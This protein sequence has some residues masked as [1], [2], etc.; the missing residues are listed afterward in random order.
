MNEMNTY[1]ILK[2][3]C[4]ACYSEKFI[5]PKSESRTEINLKKFDLK[6]AAKETFNAVIIGKRNT[7]KSVLISEILYY[8]TKSKIPR[9][10]V[11]S[12]TEESN[13]FFCKYI[14]DTY[15]FNAL[16]VESRLEMIVQNQKDLIMKKKLGH[17]PI[18]TDLKVVVVLDDI[19]YKKGALR[20]EI[21][22]EIFCNGRHYDI[23]VILAAQHVM[24]LDPAVRSNCDYVICLKESNQNSKDHLYKNFFGSFEKNKHFKNAFDAMTQNYG[25]LVLNNKVQTGIIDDT[26]NWYK[27]TCGREFKLGSKEFWKNHN[28]KYVT[29]VDRYLMK[30]SQNED[31]TMISN[32]GGVIVRKK[33]K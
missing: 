31:N 10:C 21:V 26:V 25:C 23:T 20:S 13:G 19:G 28:E 4:F 33:G 11:I 14:P 12:A 29:D 8:L 3:K 9:A 7:G 30:N 15:I 32:D 16:D 1:V 18:D 17:I 6:K 24:Q 5:M 27:A 22:K 2:K